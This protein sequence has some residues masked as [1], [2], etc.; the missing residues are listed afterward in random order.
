VIAAPALAALALVTPVAWQGAG[1]VETQPAAADEAPA[2]TDPEPPTHTELGTLIEQAV[3]WLVEHQQPD[4]SWGTHHTARPIE[5]LASIPGS[6][7]AFK[8]ATTALVVSALRDCP[9][10]GE[11]GFRAAE[12]GLDFL[13]ANAAVKRQSGLEHY[14]VWSFGFA[15]ETLGDHLLES[16]EDERNPEVR[17]AAARLVEKLERYQTLDGGWGYLSLDAVPTMKPS[18]TSM[19][20]TTAT[21]LLG[22]ARARDAGLELPEGVAEKAVAHLLRSRLPDGAFL[23]GEYLKYRP[24]H[25]INERPGSACRTP[26]CHYALE[27]FGE[28][29]TADGKQGQEVLVESLRDLLIRYAGLQRASLRRPIP[30]ESHYA[31][32]GYFYLYGHAYAAYVM[33]QLPAEAVAALWPALVEAVLVCRE[34]DGSFWDYPLYSYHKP[35]GTGFALQALSRAWLATAE[36]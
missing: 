18:Y 5:V 31:I 35:Y 34:P 11:Q 22:L 7:E 28:P 19:S 17:R 23:Y 14:N 32:S 36:E 16:P 13:I 10:A 29:P 21:C 4:G 30:H 3:A 15:L 2:P 6:Q 20:F 26:L 12:R 8:V 1:E 24:R 27:L 9:L 33:E 25:D